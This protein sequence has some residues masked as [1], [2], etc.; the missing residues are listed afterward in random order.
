MC[1]NPRTICNRHTFFAGMLLLSNTSSIYQSFRTLFSIWQLAAYC[2]VCDT[3]IFAQ[4]FGNLQN[5]ITIMIRGV[6]QK[7]YIPESFLETLRNVKS[8]DSGGS[9]KYSSPGHGEIFQPPSPSPWWW[10][11]L[12]PPLGL[13]GREFVKMDPAPQHSGSPRNKIVGTILWNASL[14]TEMMKTHI[15]HEG[16]S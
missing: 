6:S 16:F 9:P 12:Y 2:Y 7:G 8:E 1:E 13:W 5:E 11:A 4:V 15:K 3:E 14:E 10:C